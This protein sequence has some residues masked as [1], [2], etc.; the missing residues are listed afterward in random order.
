MILRRFGILTHKGLEYTGYSHLNNQIVDVDDCLF[1]SAESWTQGRESS[2]RAVRR[3]L[4]SFERV[5][6]L[7]EP[8]LI[9]FEGLCQPQIRVVLDRFDG[10]HFARLLGRHRF[11]EG[12]KS[13]LILIT[14]LLEPV[15]TLLIIHRHN[16]KSLFFISTNEN[17][18]EHCF[19]W[20]R[21]FWERRWGKGLPNWRW[22]SCRALPAD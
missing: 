10:R 22:S 18:P 5:I 14:A 16:S 7:H 20:F 6:G 19:E 8:K 21:C 3:N 9:F 13:Y 2:L 15:T 4:C 17:I 1:V 12:L 11:D